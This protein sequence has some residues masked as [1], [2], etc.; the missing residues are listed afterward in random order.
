MYNYDYP[1]KVYGSCLMISK[2]T[3]CHASQILKVCP[4]VIMGVN[5]S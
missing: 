2:K 5:D 1:E 4:Y 3:L